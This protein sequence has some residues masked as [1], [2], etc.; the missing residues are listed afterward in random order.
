MKH[1]A[2]ILYVNHAS[3]I[4]GAERCM[5]RMLDDIDRERFEPFLACPDGDLAREA[6]FRDTPVF[7]VEFLDYQRNRS[8]LIGRSVPNPFLALTHATGATL[9]GRRL[10]RIARQFKVNVIHANTLLARVP[11]YL[12]GKFSG[13]P[14]IWHIRDILSSRVW[15]TIYD[16]LARGGISGIIS[17]SNAC[18]WQFRD[19]T[20]ISTIYDGISSQVFCRRPEEADAVRHSFGWDDKSVVFGIFG[21]IT[22]WK[23]HEQFVEAAVAVNRRYSSTHWLVVGEAWSDEDQEFEAALRSRALQGGL[24]DHL[25]FTGF[26]NDVSSLMSACDVVVVPSIKPD[27]FPNTVLEG[28]ACSR[29]VVA[30]PVGG[31]PEAIEDGISGRLVTQMDA[32]GLASAMMPLIEHRILRETL[33]AHAR[34]RVVE[35]FSPEKTQRRI[36]QVY[37]TIL[38]S[39]NQ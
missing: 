20:K 21:R 34:K 8:K 27:P 12:T 14:V 19:Q 6:E 7:R 28:M 39:E 23:G 10:S 30:F 13:V 9:I 24:A 11:A 31:I 16:R 17:V 15:L 18:R 1:K 32:G 5:I 26:R 2:R 4:S 37:D 38:G 29:A 35:K 36:E 33:G 25:I 3:K 22:T